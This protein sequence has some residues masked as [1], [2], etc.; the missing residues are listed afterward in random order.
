[1]NFGLN[2][3]LEKRGNLF[4]STKLTKV[5]D[6]LYVMDNYFLMPLVVAIL[7]IHLVEKVKVVF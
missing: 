6:H 3:E 1:M 7:H 5:L 4:S 2:L